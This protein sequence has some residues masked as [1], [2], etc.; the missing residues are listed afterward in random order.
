M[1]AVNRKFKIGDR[2][3]LSRK[4]GVG[5][6][7]FGPGRVVGYDGEFVEVL[8]DETTLSNPG[9]WYE[10]SLE[11]ESTG[12]PTASPFER[13]AAEI[14][15]LVTEKNAA[16]SNSAEK[17]ARILEILFPSGV[18]V[19]QYKYMQLITRICDKLARLSNGHIKD[20]GEDIAG[21][22]IL[23]AAMAENERET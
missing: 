2:V 13:I 9:G 6:D 7:L 21:Y 1:E 4:A 19:E 5:I 11:L 22:G 3:R 23:I 17:T 14:G 8:H 20:S 12:T 15:K 18:S 16:Y 10:E